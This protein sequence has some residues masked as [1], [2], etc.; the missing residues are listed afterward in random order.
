MTL[1]LIACV[2]CYKDQGSYYTGEWTE[3]ESIENLTPEEFK[4]L[5]TVTLV[6]DE[7]FKLSPKIKFK[8]GVNPDNYVYSWIMG[9]DTIARSVNLDWTVIKTAEMT[10]SHDGR[11][12]L[13]LD[14][15]NK[16]SGEA[17]KLFLQ[18]SSN[19]QI[20]FEISQSSTPQIAT[21]VYEGDNSTIEWGS[22]AGV[23]TLAPSEYSKL[24]VDMFKRYNP[25]REIKGSVINAVN[26][27]S[28]LIVYTNT[29]PDYGVMIQTSEK[30]AQPLGSYVSSVAEQ[31]YQGGPKSQVNGQN[32]YNGNMQELLIGEDLYVA[33]TASAPHQVIFPSDEASMGDVAQTM[34]V[35]PYINSMHFS[36]LRKSNGELYYYTFNTAYALK[37]YPLVDTANNNIKADEI[38]GVVRQPTNIMKE[39]KF[40]VIVKQSGE[41]NLYSFKLEQH[42]NG[43]ADI[44]YLDKHDVSTWAGGV[45]EETMW[46]TN[47]VEVP[48]NYLYIV[49][50]KALYR[51]SYESLAT[52]VK[53]MDF[54]HNVSCATMVSNATVANDDLEEKCLVVFVHNSSSNESTMK[55]LDVQ[56]SDVQ[57]ISQPE[58]IIPGKVVKY[59]PK[60]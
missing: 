34:G 14:I 20:S 23:S 6:E 5:Y 30:G 41:Y 33:P 49:N 11:Y 54:A 8:D 57:L 55:V 44:E 38:I 51:T 35:N 48:G 40:F 28:N 27:G 45:S 24:Y 29:E 31:V 3:I 46:M 7:V 18:N 36:V 26:T 1:A 39:I 25:S 10:P 42:E 53:V 9:G 17:W 4:S 32:F 58:T 16:N 59:L 52:P 37:S 47:I 19:T 60:N 13:W 56:S 22:V 12:S 15:E 43:N 2:S 50:G 21:F